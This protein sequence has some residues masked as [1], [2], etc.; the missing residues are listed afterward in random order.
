MSGF[1][2]KRDD[3]KPSEMTQDLKNLRLQYKHKR[4]ESKNALVN[5]YRS[6]SLM[7][8]DDFHKALQK[9]TPDLFAK[10]H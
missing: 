10:A 4:L 1:D 7:Q 2:L 6:L 9:P 5:H 8:G 3:V